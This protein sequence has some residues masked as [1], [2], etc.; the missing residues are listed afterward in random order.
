MFGISKK[1]QPPS[2][3]AFFVVLSQPTSCPYFRAMAELQGINEARARREREKALNAS[4]LK[5]SRATRKDLMFQIAKMSFEER[6][7]ATNEQRLRET[8]N[9]KAGVK[10]EDGFPARVNFRFPIQGMWVELGVGNQRPKGSA[11]AK[12]M[13][14]P[15]IST[16]LEP[17]LT[18]LADQLADAY[19][20][21]VSEQVALNVPGYMRSTIT[22]KKNG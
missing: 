17:Q 13:A 22:G 3:L 12:S 15:W 10:R 19:A 11:K 20:D 9:V 2:G 4:V 14:R 16:A 5:W 21:I 6:A 1:S 18:V 8:K 7:A